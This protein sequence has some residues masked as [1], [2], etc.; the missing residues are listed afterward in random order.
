MESRSHDI[1]SKGASYF[2]QVIV[3]REEETLHLEF[4]TLSHDGGQLKR[5][6]RKL[7]AAAVT[8]LSNAEG[9]VLIIGIETKRMDG[10]DVASAKRP[11]KQLQRTTNLIRSAIPE[12]LSPQH[13]GLEAH[14][15]EASGKIDEGFIVID[16]PESASRPHYSNVHHQY[17]RRGSDGTRVMEHG[18]IRDLMFATREGLLEI[19][20]GLRMSSSTEDLKYSLQLVLALRNVGSVPVRAPYLRLAKQDWHPASSDWVLPRFGVSTGGFYTTPDLIIHIEDEFGVA[21]FPTGLDFRRTGLYQ[22]EAAIQTVKSG[23][24]N[25][26]VMKPME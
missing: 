2:D 11:I 10:V 16:V 13:S 12:M 5:K 21:T 9:G 15:V 24:W 25:R 3:D 19:S 26:V 8:G 1:L 17:F 4:K 7:V 22:L 14:A 18:E 6:D 20:C 23:Q